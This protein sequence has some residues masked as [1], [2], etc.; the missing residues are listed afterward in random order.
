[1]KNL[2]IF[3]AVALAL[4]LIG[5]VAGTRESAYEELPPPPEA[6]KAAVVAAQPA[7]SYTELRE[8]TPGPNANWGGNLQPLS[9]TAQPKD[10]D[11]YAIG[12][13]DERERRAGLR[14]Y[15]GAPPLVPHPVSQRDAPSC[16]ACHADGVALP[17]GRIAPPVSHD[18]FS[19]CVQCH[20]TADAA[21]PVAAEPFVA[22]SFEGIRAAGPGERAWPGAPPTIP[23]DT[24]MRTRCVSCHGAHTEPGLASSH[25]T[26]QSCTQCHAESRPLR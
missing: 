18:E 20:A 1:M 26:R 13:E 10:W 16:L 6:A 25:P 11:E 21:P 8:R 23:H 3:A 9:T 22:N 12:R 15:D 19:S 2:E 5:F 24:F 7:A 4:A 14:A 17:D